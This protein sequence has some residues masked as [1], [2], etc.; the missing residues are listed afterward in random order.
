MGKARSLLR[1]LSAGTAGRRHGCKA[2][3]DHVLF[4]GDTMLI[5]KIDRDEYHYCVDCAVA[6]IATARTNLTT[7]EN[8]L[9]PPS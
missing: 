5:V 2:N 1:S 8:A 3:K 6:F 7:L 4:K 9:R